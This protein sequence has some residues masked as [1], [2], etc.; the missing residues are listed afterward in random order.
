M[1]FRFSLISSGL[2]SDDLSLECLRNLGSLLFTSESLVPES[3]VPSATGAF[4]SF[5]WGN[6][7]ING[8]GD[9]DLDLRSKGTD[10]FL[11]N[12]SAGLFFSGLDKLGLSDGTGFRGLESG[13][14]GV[15][16][17]VSFLWGSFVCDECW[18]P[19][20]SL[21]SLVDAGALSDWEGT[22]ILFFSECVVE[23]GCTAL[24]GMCGISGTL[25]FAGT[26]LA[27][28]VKMHIKKYNFTQSKFQTF[29][30]TNC[31]KKK[32]EAP[33]TERVQE[34]LQNSKRSL[35]K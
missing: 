9:L 7:G 12:F 26:E 3:L 2:S 21:G 29:K 35:E 17:L 34:Y 32:K 6:L 5:A 15:L 33:H 11:G 10:S 31:K 4:P 24:A 23:V 13:G 27:Y 1:L 8:K 14:A 25:G 22:G 20:L 30:T 16:V 18:F 19:L 28:K